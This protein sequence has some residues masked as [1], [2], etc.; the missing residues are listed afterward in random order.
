[1][2]A[3]KGTAS[4]RLLGMKFMQRAAASGNQ[5]SAPSTP[6]GRPAKRARLSNGTGTPST[7]GLSDQQRLQAAQAEEE[8]QRSAV[9]ARLAAEA[10]E[11][12]W[13]LN[14]KEPRAK[15]A[16]M[17]II[18]AGFADLD[19][20][21]DESSDSEDA[22]NGATTRFVAGRMVFG[23]LKKYQQPTETKQ[24]PSSDSGSGSS[25]DSSDN[26]E[27]E[28]DSYKD[29]RANYASKKE[30]KSLIEQQRL[31]ALRR[32]KEIKLNQGAAP[33]RNPKVMPKI[34]EDADLSRVRSISGGGQHKRKGDSYRPGGRR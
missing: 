5:S 25:D 24:E 10:G 30:N 9:M 13:V 3:Q 14:V 23:Q 11:T 4:T 32:K 12:H 22:N 8:L 15:D 2:S 18:Q 21:D 1:M 19:S 34:E 16:P 31:A 29:I 28:E 27:H 7:P 20:V 17:N 6:D 26:S 33:N